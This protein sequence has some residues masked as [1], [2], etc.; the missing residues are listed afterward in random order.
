MRLVLKVKNLWYLVEGTIKMEDGLPVAATTVASDENPFG[1]L[2]IDSI[3]ED[4]ID[5]LVEAKTAK[6]M[7][8][9][10]ETAHHHTSAG[11]RY[12][13]LRSLMALQVS[14][15]DDI[16]DHLLNISKLGTRL[17]KMCRDGKISVD[18]IKVAA[19]TS[20]LP[21]SFA[22]VTSRYESQDQ[23]TY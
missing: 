8:N 21:S 10:L 22:G 15:D 13:L 23:V 3:H 20:S 2:L 14:D 7:W 11:T 17:R 19:L 18:D 16:I 5:L 6:S 4:N 9:S 12:H 1:A